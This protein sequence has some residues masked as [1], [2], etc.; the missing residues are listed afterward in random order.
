MVGPT[1]NLIS[2]THH[3]C[4]RREYTFIILREWLIPLISWVQR[5][6]LTFW[7]TRSAE[8][9]NFLRNFRKAN[10]VPKVTEIHIRETLYLIQS[11]RFLIKSMIGEFMYVFT[12]LRTVIPYPIFDFSLF[13]FW[14]MSKTQITE[15]KKKK[16]LNV[17]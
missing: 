6:I 7:E 2:G 5:N 3:S 1:M 14:F 13:K 12:R 11:L 8:Y 16:S 15:T 4:E 10:M 9:H 17:A